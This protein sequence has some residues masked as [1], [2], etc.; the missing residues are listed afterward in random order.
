M[1]QH[2]AVSALLHAIDGMARQVL[3]READFLDRALRQQA[4]LSRRDL[5]TLAHMARHYLPRHRA[6]QPVYRLA[7]RGTQQ[8]EGVLAL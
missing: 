6:T 7:H 3:P 1:P 8:E 2:P 4:P 5:A